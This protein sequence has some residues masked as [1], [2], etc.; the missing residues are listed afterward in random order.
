MAILASKFVI[1]RC[2][3]SPKYGHEWLLYLWCRGLMETL[4]DRVRCVCD[5]ANAD[6]VEHMCATRGPH[7]KQWLFAMMDSL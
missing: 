1:G 3:I 7:A 6:M 5:V 4:F 2:F